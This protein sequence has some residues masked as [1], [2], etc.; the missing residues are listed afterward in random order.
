MNGRIQR[1]RLHEG[2]LNEGFQRWNGTYAGG[3]LANNR[4]ALDYD[5]LQNHNLSLF[6]RVISELCKVT[7][8][9]TPEFVA[10][11]QKGESG[12]VTRVAAE[13][14][15][16]P[17][18]LVH[19]N[20]H[21]AINLSYAT[22]LDE[23][24]AGESA[25]RGVLIED[26]VYD[27]RTTRAALELGDLGSKIIAAVAIFDRSLP[28]ENLQVGVPVRSLATEPIPTMLGRSK[29]WQFAK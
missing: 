26:V 19:K 17:V 23:Y 9:Y 15:I 25:P 20:I 27:R 24:I 18:L 2:L 5:T 7:Q 11:V 6:G 28:N 10:G 4:L 22:E 3:V 29:L 1:S 13:L 21:G 16:Q 14:D 8:A 12:Y